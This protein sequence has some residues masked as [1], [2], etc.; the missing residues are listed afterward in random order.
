[1]TP[2]V[3]TAHFSQPLLNL[4][5]H[6]NPLSYLVDAPRSLFV[7]GRIADPAG[8][9]WSILFSIIVLWVGLHAFY[10]IK[11]KVTERL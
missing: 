4:V 9:A 7:L 3:Y 10:L 11:D 8:Y 5:V 1:V 2:V 6:W